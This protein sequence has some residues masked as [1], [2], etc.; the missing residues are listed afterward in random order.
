MRREASVLLFQDGMCERTTP[1][2]LALAT[3]YLE[4]SQ[5]GAN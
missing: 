1:R 4:R 5:I 3:G 2:G